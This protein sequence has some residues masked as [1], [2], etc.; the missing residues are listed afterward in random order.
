[1]GNHEA[2][3]EKLSKLPDEEIK[4]LRPEE[5]TEDGRRVLKEELNR[6]RSKEYGVQVEAEK[7]AFKIHENKMQV[8]AT[9]NSRAKKY[10]SLLMCFIGLPLL[11]WLDLVYI[12]PTRLTWAGKRRMEIFEKQLAELPS[13]D[14]TFLRKVREGEESAHTLV[15]KIFFYTGGCGLGW[16]ISFI[17][18]RTILIVSDRKNTLKK[19]KNG[20]TRSP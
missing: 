18:I 1:M 13:E 15:A 16:F 20:F 6:R 2:I 10:A 4:K 3:A 12:K 9:L 11:I 19:S 8:V 14:A 17:S 5:M 7:Q